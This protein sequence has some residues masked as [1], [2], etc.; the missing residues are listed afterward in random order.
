[1]NCIL[2]AIDALRAQHVSCNGYG[3]NTSPNLDELASQG[4]TFTDCT[5]GYAYTAP[6]FTTIFTGLYVFNHKVSGNPHGTPNANELM[7]DD[8]IPTL[9][10]LIAQEDIITAAV[11]NLIEFRSHLKQ[12]VRGYRYYINVTRPREQRQQHVTAD[13]LNEEILPWLRAHADQDFFLFIHYWDPHQ[14]FVPPT[15]FDEAFQGMDGMSVIEGLGGREYVEHV[16]YRDVLDE[17][18]LADVSHYDGEIRYVDDRI[19]QILNLLNELGIYEET[20]IV[21]TADHGEIMMELPLTP[22]CMRGIWHPTMQVPLI[23]RLPHFAPKAHSCSALAHHVDIVP[24]VLEVFGIQTAAPLDGHSLVPLY[25]GEVDALREEVVGEATYC[26][27]AQRLL[28]DSVYKLIKNSVPKPCEQWKP[29]RDDVICP[30]P[31]PL[32]LYDIA[33]DPYELANLGPEKADLA[34][35]MEER[36]NSAI[37]AMMREGEDPFRE[38][39]WERMWTANLLFN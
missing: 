20:A 36:L 18:K 8:T 25:M 6:S 12:F 23:I 30:D 35:Q 16:G 31:Q 26:G 13:Q 15:P 21:V 4:V 1:M 11:D 27:V 2:I 32:E 33:S 9:A 37:A 39:M 5:P 14:P 17:E 19:G 3:R 29:K 22:F 28:K 24:T 10:E 7:L 34:M 38:K